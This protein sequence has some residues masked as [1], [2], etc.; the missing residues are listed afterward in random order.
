MV[1][2]VEWEIKQCAEWNDWLQ[3]MAPHKD[4]IAIKEKMSSYHTNINQN[5]KKWWINEK[6]KL[7]HKHNSEYKH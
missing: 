2:Q 5:K 1:L 3:K 6:F 7:Y 4:S